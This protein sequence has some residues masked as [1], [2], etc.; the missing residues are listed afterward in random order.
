MMDFLVISYGLTFAA[1][2]G[3]LASVWYMKRCDARALE[4]FEET[5]DEE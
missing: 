5:T 4:K 2:V 3:L 1:L